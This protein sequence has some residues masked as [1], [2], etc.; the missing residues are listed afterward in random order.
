[1]KNEYLVAGCNIWLQHSRERSLLMCL[2]RLGIASL[3]MESFPSQARFVGEPPPIAQP[4][5]EAEGL[6]ELLKQQAAERDG[7]AA[8]M[9][10][11]LA[12]G[13]YL[14]VYN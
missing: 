12:H 1:M 13:H 14:F 11:E 2:K 10:D 7:R 4:R 8:Q 5:G 9:R 6:F 3:D